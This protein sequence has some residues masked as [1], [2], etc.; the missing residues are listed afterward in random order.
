[1]SQLTS[2]KKKEA[3]EKQGVP[4]FKTLALGKQ[5]KLIKWRRGRFSQPS[6]PSTEEAAVK[7]VLVAQTKNNDET[8]AALHKEWLRVRPQHDDESA[9]QDE[10]QHEESRLRE[11]ERE[12]EEAG[13]AD[14]ATPREVDGDGGGDVDE[15]GEELSGDDSDGDSDGE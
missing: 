7:R 8:R 9:V 12:A 10:L 13:E 4:V 11:A 1:M 2:A 5:V 6:L 15:A 3:A 14:A